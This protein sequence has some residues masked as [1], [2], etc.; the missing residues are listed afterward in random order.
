[1]PYAKPLLAIAGISASS[2]HPGMCC[3]KNIAS[4]SRLQKLAQDV[5]PVQDAA[6][7]TQQPKQP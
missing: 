1:M 3:T 6:R 2:G 5:N 4:L 7:F